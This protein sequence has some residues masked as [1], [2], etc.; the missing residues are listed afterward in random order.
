MSEKNV[1]EAFK[2]GGIIAYPT[3]AVFGLGCDPD[4]KEALKRLLKLKQRSPEKGLILLAGSYSQLLP[5]IDDS[6][7]PQDKRLTLL[8]RWPDGITQLV[9][10]NN[11]ISSLLSGSFDTIAV[12][13]TS[14]PDVVAL[15]QQTN[16]P[17]VSTSANLSGQEPAKTWQSLDLVLS[18]Q[19]D[20][21]LKGVTLGRTSPSKIIDALTG[22]I[23]RN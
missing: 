22:K 10:K 7:I 17:I 14:Q 11:N 3:E 9:P 13:I 23:I 6:K 12:R 1:V 2:N 20:F 21:I 5:Y 8:S 15:C 18:K 4:N 16:K 19:V